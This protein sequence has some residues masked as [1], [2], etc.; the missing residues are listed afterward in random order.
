MVYMSRS[1]IRTCH[2]V[3]RINILLTLA[4]FVSQAC[5]MHDAGHHHTTKQTSAH[6][7][8]TACVSADT[9]CRVPNV[10]VRY[11]STAMANLFSQ[12]LASIAPCFYY[13][14]MAVICKGPP[15]GGFTWILQA[16][17]STSLA[18]SSPCEARL[19]R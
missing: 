1:A 7:Q 5:M 13:P 15:N 3:S 12:G 19:I 14:P 2:L 8:R 9:Q 17:V 16:V 10:C 11:T 6:S 4:R 18:F